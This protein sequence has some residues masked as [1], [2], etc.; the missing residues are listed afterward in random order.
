MAPHA[1]PVALRIVLMDA[2]KRKADLARSRMAAARK[3]AVA[4]VMSQKA[5]AVD[6]I[7]GDHMAHTAHA[8]RSVVILDMFHPVDN[9]Y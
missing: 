4:H 2:P 1:C 3:A 6:I 8:H 9:A 5:D 7:H